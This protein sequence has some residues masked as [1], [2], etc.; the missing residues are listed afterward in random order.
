MSTRR[1]ARP[2][3]RT[4]GVVGLVVTLV[5]TTL[6]GIG[7]PA[8]ATTAQ[9]GRATAWTTISS[10]GDATPQ[11]ADAQRIGL[12]DPAATPACTVETVRRAEWTFGDLPVLGELAPSDVTSAVL[13]VRTSD[14]PSCG[15]STVEVYALPEQGADW[16]SASAWTTERKVDERAPSYGDPCPSVTPRYA[17]YDVTAAV[18]AAA[19]AR[20]PLVVGLKIADETC[21]SC[22][23][24][25]TPGA[26]ISVRYNRAPDT[27]TGLVTAGRSCLPGQ[28][29]WVRD[30][31][32]LSASVS[33]P[34][35]GGQAPSVTFTV[36][37]LA[38]PATPVW[39]ST[40]P[41]GSHTVQV[42]D[43]IA[44]DGQA[45]RWTVVAVDS[46][47]LSSRGASCDFRADFTPPRSPVIIT[48][49]LGEPALYLEDGWG[50]GGGMRGSFEL[51]ADPADDVVRFLYDFDDTALFTSVP[52]GRDAVVSYTP[53]SS[54]MPH[55]LTAQAV[56][57]AGNVGPTVTYRFFVA[58]SQAP[59]API[60]VAPVA[61]RTYG[62]TM[63]V[64]VRISDIDPTPSGTLLLREGSTRLG[65]A[66]I[67]GRTT[68]LTIPARAL[69]A[70]RH[71]LQ[72]TFQA[73][74]QTGA[75]S[76]PVT[77]SVAKAAASVVASTPSRS[78]YG[79][80]RTVS[81]RVEA[82]AGSGTPTGRVSVLWGTRTL[83]AATL[84]AGRAT[85]T[86]PRA[87]VPAG[88]HVLTVRYG[89]TSSVAPAARKV[90]ITVLKAR[91]STTGRLVDGH[92]A[93]GT[94][95]RMVV[96]VSAAHVTP[97]G[98]VEILEHGRLVAKAKLHREDSG[99]VSV[100]LPVLSAGSHRL[101]VRYRG[102]TS[103]AADA[104]PAR[105][106]VVRRAT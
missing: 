42:P 10:A 67:T 44:V 33:D 93:A 34:D 50:G 100:R 105:T 14:G 80:T 58:G 74:P 88:K 12:C 99:R 70:G 66:T 87:S 23:R 25:V 56:D 43:G 60:T 83:A 37:G 30:A 94:H 54:S 6:A 90:A 79:G 49:V 104:A 3:W 73:H 27:P 24:D 15:A 1:D 68:R 69:A 63:P 2:T 106:L 78:T 35:G 103:I 95:G 84:T 20:T 62:S 8:A 55:T 102:T 85:V 77:V 31:P 19:D 40:Q 101:T 4:L 45:Y 61:T 82:Q 64:D 98:T 11:F 47:G 75:S 97:T 39:T 38:D 22:A 91:A 41:P 18:R 16:G 36:F 89:G 72:V 71:T 17:E 57:A 29:V 51:A 96:R 32:M 59:P 21:S 65:A 92:I 86:L 46:D 28:P 48:P 81:V 26:T 52:A 76:I 7:G 5:A 9:S 53:P 13:V